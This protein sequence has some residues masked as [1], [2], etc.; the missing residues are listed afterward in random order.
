MKEVIRQYLDENHQLVIRDLARLKRMT[1]LYKKYYKEKIYKFITFYDWRK[2]RLCYPKSLQLPLTNRCNL[3]CVMCNIQAKEFKKEIPIDKF[4][5]LL[6]DSI[7]KEII[8]VGLNGGEPFLVKDIIER[9]KI[10]INKLKKLKTIYIISNGVLT[11]TIEERLPEIKRYCDEKNI[12]LVISIS[13]D[14][15]NDVHDIV[16]AQNGTFEKAVNTISMIQKDENKYCHYLNIICTV[17]KFNVYSLNELENFAKQQKW[18]ISYNIATEHERLKNDSKYNDFSL[19]TD[20]KAKSMAREFFFKKFQETQSQIYYAIFRYLDY[21]TPVRVCGCGYLKSG[22][23]ITP[24]GEVCYCATHSK[25]IGSIYDKKSIK[26]I[27]FSNDKYNNSLKKE[28]CK[29]CS[30]YIMENLDSKEYKNF[31]RQCLSQYH[32][33]KL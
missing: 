6:E 22:I 21:E 7:F 28:Y 25:A 19:Q 24:E 31:I 9:V 15:I 27:Y 16:R 23:T 14:G 29:K 2:S 3:D 20:E 11:K 1:K 33:Y 5:T 32:K 12:K 13:I 8:S 10:L 30:H 17:S 18:N 26:D 4:E